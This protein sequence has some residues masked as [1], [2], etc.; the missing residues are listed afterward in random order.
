MKIDSAAVRKCLKSF[1]FKTLFRE[2]L[3][4]DNHH[5]QL[6]IPLPAD[7]HGADGSTVRLTA[8]AQKR[9]FVAFVCPSIPDRATRLKIDH[10]IT[11]S[12]REHFV[13][14]AD[15]S[16]G[17]QVWQWVRREQG[18]PLASRDHRFDASQSGDRLIQRLEQIAVSLDEEE[19][20]TVIEGLRSLPND[21]IIKIITR[22]T[23]TVYELSG[24]TTLDRPAFRVRTI[25]HLHD[26]VNAL[27]RGDTVS[28]LAKAKASVGVALFNTEAPTNE[29]LEAK[30]IQEVA[31]KLGVVRILL[32]AHADK[33]EEDLFDWGC[34][35]KKVL[36]DYVTK[37]RWVKSKGDWGCRLKNPA[38]ML[39][40]EPRSRYVPAIVEHTEETRDFKITTIHGVKGETHDVTVLYVPKTGV[41]QC[42]AA[43]WW[44]A[45]PDHKEERR[46]AFVATSRP[47]HL[48]V[49]CA[50]ENTVDRLRKVHPDFVALF[51]EI[52]LDNKL[53]ESLAEIY[54]KACEVVPLEEE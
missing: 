10:Q 40:K 9:G 20:I 2:H 13:I 5:A 14:Y 47:R 37:M 22:K 54:D 45:K 12:A 48:F 26:A 28:A 18:K 4:W 36:E 21:A 43:T 15:Q 8:F 53:S 17:Q 24:T 6:D 11:R 33:S 38:S 27:R 29:M 31:W 51:Q 19:K 39:K 1:D 25:N 16:S 23:R 35:T 49:L 42:P 41:E 52:A 34:R 46:V 3:G 30:R 32:S 50:H 44:P 7:R